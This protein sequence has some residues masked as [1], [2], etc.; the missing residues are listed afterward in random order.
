MRRSVFS[1]PTGIVALLAIVMF[2]GFGLLCA[3]RAQTPAVQ[4]IPLSQGLSEI[5][6]GRVDKVLL[7]NDRATLTLYDGSRQQTNTGGSRDALY[8]AITEYNRAN[9]AK[10]IQVRV[11]DRYPFGQ[12]L[13]SVVLGF[14]PL[15]ALVA[16]IVFAASPSRVLAHRIRT[17]DWR[18]SP[19]SA[20]AR[21]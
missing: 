12:T 6:E 18:A 14:L 3:Y 2:L 15:A 5:H 17:S 16:L 7:E 4:T 10:D 11:D 20:T 13:F 9:P 8:Q 19:T 1:G 21:C